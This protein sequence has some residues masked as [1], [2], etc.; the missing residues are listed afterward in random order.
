M[1]A[2]R[3]GLISQ[4][5]TQILTAD[6]LLAIQSGKGIPPDLTTIPGTIEQVEQSVQLQKQQQRDREK[7]EAEQKRSLAA[8]LKNQQ[9]RARRQAQ[10]LTNA[11]KQAF[12]QT[13]FK[14]EKIRM[15]GG[16]GVPLVILLLLFLVLIPVN[17]HT[18]IT[19]LWFAIVRHAQ[20][21]DKP[22]TGTT[23][24]PIDTTGTPGATGPGLPPP[25]T[26]PQPL[27]PGTPPI[28]PFTMI[29]NYADVMARV[30][31]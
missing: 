25:V 9:E 14:V 18:R 21:S 28:S 7:Q 31:N 29:T 17:G 26:P 3:Q 11:T 13:T 23:D 1:S 6:Q 10:V 16:I 19:W 27:P 22:S 30:D 5:N 2:A 24:H 12:K 20:F 15:P 8:Q 4:L